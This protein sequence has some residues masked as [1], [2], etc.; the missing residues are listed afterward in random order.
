MY[1]RVTDFTIGEGG[2]SISDVKQNNTNNGII[3]DLSGKIMTRPQKGIYIK[4]GKKFI[5]RK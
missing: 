4:N 2:S 1:N 3:Y 5:Q